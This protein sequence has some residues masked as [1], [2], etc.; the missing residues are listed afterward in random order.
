M[1]EIKRTPQSMCMF[2][3]EIGVNPH[4]YED[5]V[6]EI[7]GICEWKWVMMDEGS[8][9]TSWTEK[10][11]AQKNDAERMIKITKINTLC[12][13]R[14]RNF[15]VSLWDYAQKYTCQVISMTAK[16]YKPN[17]EGRRLI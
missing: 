8:I 7:N 13:M 15:P 1:K 2:F 16:E 5:N 3:D 6:K 9:K 11:T 14:Q 4:M 10:H 12:I 17:I